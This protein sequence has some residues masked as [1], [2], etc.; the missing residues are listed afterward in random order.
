MGF[1]QEAH[2]RGIRPE[3]RFGLLAADFALTVAA[4]ALATSVSDVHSSKP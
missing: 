4:V 2:V 1:G 3:L